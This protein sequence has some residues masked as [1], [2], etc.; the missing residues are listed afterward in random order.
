MKKEL[1]CIML[2]DDDQ[3]D[4]FFHER[5]IKKADFHAS[6]IAMDSAIAAL[7]YLKSMK[8]TKKTQPDL[9]F[10]DINMPKMDGWEFLM[11]FSQL[12]KSIQT[13][14]M[15]MI[16]TTSNNITDKFR[17]K[18]WSFVRGYLTKP[19]TKGIIEDINRTYFK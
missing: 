17:A 5:E 19:L 2:I 10:L 14:V 9:I 18:A 6:V 7:E 13:E 11:E 1:N 8:E 16:L 15:I 12:E 3:S 4:N